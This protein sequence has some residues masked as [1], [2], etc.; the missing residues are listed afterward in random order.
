VVPRARGFASKHLLWGLCLAV[1]AAQAITTA[2]NDWSLL[3]ET[4]LVYRLSPEPFYPFVPV[5]IDGDGAPS[6]GVDFSQ[7]YLSAAA[8]RAGDAPYAP[9]RPEFRDRYARHPNYPPLTNHLYVPLTFLDYRN[10]LAVHTVAGLLLFLGLAVTVMAK[11][12]LARH[13]LGVC[14]A[15]LLLALKTPIGFSHLERGQFDLFVAS[16]ILLVAAAAY[17]ESRAL[18]FTVAACLV[19]AMKWTSIPVLL[20][21]SLLGIATAS[22]G[23]RR[24]VYAAIPLVLAASA[25]PFASELSGYWPSLSAYELEAAPTGMTFEHWLPP[26][27]AKAVPV[28]CTL[29]F[30]ATLWLRSARIT[31]REAT[32]QAVAVPFGLA[33]ALQSQC[34]LRIAYEYRTVA[35]LGFLPIA[36]VWMERTTVVPRG[37]RAA[38]GMLLGGFFV[39]AFRVFDFIGVLLTPEQML[40]TFTVSALAFLSLAVA[41]LWAVTG[42]DSVTAPAADPGVASSTG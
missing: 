37:L 25:L 35:L 4:R 34:M 27:M 29:A 10:A 17:V 12:G 16:S 9:K 15:V 38:V 39:V 26:W 23:R 13:A 28:V 7:V 24:W 6:L 19:G 18:A 31:N 20:A 42:P 3:R 11:F 33:V 40:T 5:S 14:A 41:I 21:F 32:F 22:T 1:L 8:L 36:V 2:V 30:T